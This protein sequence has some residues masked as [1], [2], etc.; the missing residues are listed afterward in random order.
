MYCSRYSDLIQLNFKSDI[1]LDKSISNFPHEKNKNMSN[2]IFYILSQILKK[3][4]FLQ[5]I[6]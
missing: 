3:Y 1:A 6:I 4:F 2:I 5:N